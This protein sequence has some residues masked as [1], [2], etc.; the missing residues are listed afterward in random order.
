M[1]DSDPSWEGFPSLLTA[2]FAL[3]KTSAIADFSLGEVVISRVANKSHLL[4]ISMMSTN[5]KSLPNGSS[6][7]G[8]TDSAISFSIKI[9][10]LHLQF[11]LYK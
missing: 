4:S 7:S 1:I 3:T 10:Y 2:F 11:H 9:S 6:K 8:Q 5:R